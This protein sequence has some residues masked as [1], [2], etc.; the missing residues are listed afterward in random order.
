MLQ[1]LS[2]GRLLLDQGVK[3]GLLLVDTGFQLAAAGQLQPQRLTLLLVL[4]QLKGDAGQLLHSRLVQLLRFCL[5]ADALLHHRQIRLRC[6]HGRPG[7][8]Q[9]R[10]SS[11]LRRPVGTAGGVDRAPAALDVVEHGQIQ[12]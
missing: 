3:H 5:L 1:V 4:G 12:R 7:Q 8:L 9:G 10:T 6:R 11:D 2:Q